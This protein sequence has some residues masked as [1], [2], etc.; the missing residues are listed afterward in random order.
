[1]KKLYRLL[2]AWSCKRRN[3][4]WFDAIRF[5]TTCGASYQFTNCRVIC[6]DITV[7]VTGTGKE[8]AE[9]IQR[10][11]ERVNRCADAT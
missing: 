2:K 11:F 6:G 8:C 9:Q 3:R 10:A 7:T 1:M 5:F 4:C